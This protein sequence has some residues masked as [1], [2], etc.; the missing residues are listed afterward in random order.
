MARLVEPMVRLHRTEL[1]GIC[2]RHKSIMT[3]QFS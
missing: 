3:G 1:A 2:V